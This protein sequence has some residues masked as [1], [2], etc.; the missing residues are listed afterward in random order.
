MDR[1]I[2]FR[3]IDE[4][5]DDFIYGQAFFI[6]SDNKQGYISNGI[7][8]HHCVKKETVCEY[9]GLNDKNGVEIYEGDIVNCKEF[10]NNAISLF[11]ETQLE[12]FSLEEIKGEKKLEYISPI[13]FEEGSFFV[14]E[15]EQCD[16]YLSLFYGD[17][18][19]SQ[20]I[21]EIEV[22]GN[23]YQNKQIKI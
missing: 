22:I 17:K 1:K 12:I 11:S 23:I 21:F 14:K 20:P 19:K 3:A 2:K 8:K 10:K 18:R 16:C 15:S 7:D 4:F 5:S 13:I 6:D 9:T